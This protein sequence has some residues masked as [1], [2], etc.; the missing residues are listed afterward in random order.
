MTP[1]EIKEESDRLEKELAALKSLC[2]GMLLETH[3]PLNQEA[4]NYYIR[5]FNEAQANLKRIK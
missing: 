2:G 1:T 5:K 4:L 3:G